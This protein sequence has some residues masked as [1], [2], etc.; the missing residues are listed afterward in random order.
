VVHTLADEMAAWSLD[1]VRVYAVIDRTIGALQRPHPAL[2]P[3]NIVLDDDG[4]VEL[5]E[6]AAA[7][8]P[9]RAPEATIDEKSNVY[10][11]GVILRELLGARTELAREILDAALR[12]YAAERPTLERW[13]GMLATTGWRYRILGPWHPPFVP[14]PAERA[15]VDAVRDEG[16]RDVYADW[17]EQHGVAD[18]ARFLRTGEPAPVEDARWRALVSDARLQNCFDKECSKRWGALAPT[19]IDNVRDCTR[20]LRQVHYCP[21]LATVQNEAS[22]GAPIAIDA[23]LADVDV[24]RALV[25]MHVPTYVPPPG[26]PPQPRSYAAGAPG[27]GVLTRL[28]GLFRRR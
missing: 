3:A 6:Q 20:C 27:G 5:V 2:V 21:S 24:S 18:R 7:T 28:F 14:Q 9:Y 19:A 15:L 4:H 23:A 1:I 12:P 17:L 22:R 10:A 26:N 16:G 11:L 13:R 8:P 25:T